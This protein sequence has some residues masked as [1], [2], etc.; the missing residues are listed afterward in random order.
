MKPSK[1]KFKVQE[2][3][4]GKSIREVQIAGGELVLNTDINLLEADVQVGF[5]KTDHFIQTQF[6]V[7][8]LVTLK[9]D[10]SL[11]PFNQQVNGSY[12]ILFEP[13]EV[14]D[15]ESE[16]GAVRQIPAD[17]LAI[18]I[19]KDVRDTIMLALPVRKIH[20]DYLDSE[21]FPEEFE[22]QQYGTAPDEEEK[23][24]PRWAELKKLKE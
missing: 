13:N 5:Y 11:R 21:G 20:P 9:C 10:R 2:I 23:I 3:P 18:D 6:G 4:E 16:K 7:D 22:T 17:E 1:L 15:S 14:G 24:D 12:Q 19:E 8:A